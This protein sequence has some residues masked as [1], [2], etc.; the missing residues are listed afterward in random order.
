MFAPLSELSAFGFLHQSSMKSNMYL[1]A[2]IPTSFSVEAFWIRTGLIPLRPCNLSSALSTARLVWDV[3]RIFE[4][5]FLRIC[6]HIISA[7][8]VVLPVPGGPWIIAISGAE[9]A[10]AT[11]SNCFSLR[12]FSILVSVIRFFTSSRSSSNSPAYLGS[13]KKS[14]NLGLAGAGIFLVFER[15]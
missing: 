1:L 4:S 12:Y 2:S 6:C 10:L 13:N 8:T 14:H 15:G 7:I 11:A 5:G 9:T 3:R